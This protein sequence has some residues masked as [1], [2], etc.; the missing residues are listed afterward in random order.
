M[1]EMSI[2]RR[3]KKKFLLMFFYLYGTIKMYQL[4]KEGYITMKFPIALQLY[5]VRD[6]MA[7]D[8]EGTLR[9]V[10]AM[11]YDGVEFAGLF[12]RSAAE[13]K[14]MLEEIG[15]EAVSAHVP[16][17]DAV[18]DPEAVFSVY[19]EIGCK[20]VAVPYLTEERRPGTEG[21]P[22][23]VEGIR[24]MG[25]AAKKLGLVLLY[26]N[27]DFEFTSKIDGKYALD[28]LYETIPADLL[29]TEIDTC[30]VNVGGEDP[31]DYV[32][33]YTGRAPVVHL[34][35]FYKSGEGKGKLYELI[36]I[37]D[38]GEAA[39]STFEFRPVGYGMQDF[40]KIL[41]A[42]ETAGAQW[43]VVEQDNPS[44]D[45]FP[46]ECAAMSIEYVKGLFQ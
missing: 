34:K 38:D 30:W 37:E 25:E 23:T 4:G 27:H 10:K 18:D 16:Y 6:D 44:M 7:A 39:E 5:S 32:V 33:K 21:Y 46:L 20:Y 9:K 28:V 42:C 13:I 41:A 19:K 40:P 14:A 15:L 29:Q 31:A 12:G 11:G 24:K 1:H 3:K 45:K 43:V 36:G 17:Y 22:E 35:D 8:F 26:H 2:F